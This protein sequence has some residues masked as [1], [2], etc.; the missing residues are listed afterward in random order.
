[1]PK[2][3]VIGQDPRICIDILAAIVETERFINPKERPG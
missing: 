3:D 1:V 2:R